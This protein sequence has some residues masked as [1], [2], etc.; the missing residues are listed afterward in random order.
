MRVLP[1]LCLL[2]SAFAAACGAEV[3]G[4]QTQEHRLVCTMS[5]P[6]TQQCQWDNLQQN[7]P[8]PGI[9]VE[10]PSTSTAGRAEISLN[11]TPPMTG[12]C[13]GTATTPPELC[14]QITTTPDF[15]PDA[16]VSPTVII[17]PSQEAANGYREC[18]PAAGATC[19]DPGFPNFFAVSG[20]ASA[21][22][23]CTLFVNTSPDTPNGLVSSSPPFPIPS[24]TEPASFFPPSP[25]PALPAGPL[26]ACG[27]GLMGLATVILRK[28]RG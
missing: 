21:A 3:A 18:K 14:V 24:V 20:F 28:R 12:F 9:V 10:M 11:G 7:V 6:T 4:A 17:D 27:F 1:A 16:T 2:A 13:F 23:C 19:T 25:V 26:A 22:V 8:S 15:V 5:G